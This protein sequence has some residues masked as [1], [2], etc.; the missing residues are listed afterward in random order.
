MPLLRWSTA[1]ATSSSGI[2]TKTSRS[3]KLSTKDAK[4]R[5]VNFIE[6]DLFVTMSEGK[7][8]S[9]FRVSSLNYTTGA[10]TSHLIE[11]STVTPVRDTDQIL[12]V[13]PEE[14]SPPI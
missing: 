13:F 12:I 7:T 8:L 1:T 6:S 11:F 9:D 14:T 5:L 3:F 10:T 2:S 4:Q